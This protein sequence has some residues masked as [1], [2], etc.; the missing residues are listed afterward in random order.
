MTHGHR[1]ADALARRSVGRRI[2]APP[3]AEEAA[4]GP[5][6]AAP[7]RCPAST[8]RGCSRS[9]RATTSSRAWSRRAGARWSLRHGPIARRALPPLATPGWTLL[10]QGVDLHDDAAHRAAAS[11]FASSPDAR[12]DDVMVLVRE[13]RRRRRPARRFVRRVP[14]AGRRAGG[15]G[16]SAASRD[17][18][19]RDDVPL[20][21][22]AGFEAEPR[23]GCSSPATC[24]TCRR[25]GATTAS[26]IGECI[27][28]LDRLSRA[29]RRR[30]RAPT[31]LQRLADAARDA[32]TTR[33]RHAATALSRRGRSRRPIGRRAFRASLQRFADAAV[34]RAARPIARP[35]AAR[36]R[37][38][39]E[40][41]QAGH[42]VRARG[43]GA[44]APARDRRSTAARRMLYDERS[45][46]RQR[47]VVSRRRPRCDT[48]APPRRRG[49]GSTP[50]SVAPAER[51]GARRCSAD[52]LER[53]LVRG[54]TR[55]ST[56]RPTMN[57]DSIDPD[58]LARRV[59]R[60]RPRRLFTRPTSTARAR[61]ASSIP[62]SPTGRSTSAR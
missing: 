12:L 14:A 4:A 27:T 16:A 37:R 44:G 36:A 60:R 49:A 45:R 15:A 18:R 40:R 6:R 31:S 39:A 46:L 25:A 61:S 59:P 26:P 53:R 23:S 1:P 57:D 38:G 56:R 50:A 52:W 17:T 29:G 35:R 48:D 9:P 3:L 5:R 41:A 32:T 10:V 8:A 55:R 51:R 22:L 62:T 24:S 21:M 33:A 13:R 7:T 43:A 2:H 19:L 28:A 58:R 34:E 54:A 47:R 20:K 42:L 11:A 30:A